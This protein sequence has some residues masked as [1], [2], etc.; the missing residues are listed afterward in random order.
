MDKIIHNTDTFTT[1]SFIMNHSAEKYEPFRNSQDLFLTQVNSE[2]LK[3]ELIKIIEGA[4]T[5]LKICSF[6]ITDKEIFEVLLNKAKNDNVAVFILTQLD[7]TKLSNNIFL[8]EEE[9][10]EQNE[11]IHL[12][13]IKT[14]YDN[15]AHVR[16]STSAHAKFVIAD[17]SKGFLMSANITTPS[18]TYN[19]ESGIYLLNQN[20]NQL[21]Q[22]FDVIFQKGTSYRQYLSSS[23]SNK[24]LV[25]QNET[26]IKE[27]WLPKSNDS[28]LK[29]TYENMEFSLLNE[30]IRI[31]Q[32]SNK[33]IYI[34][35]YS[36]VALQNL[37]N[38]VFEIK[39]AV[40][41]G[42]E[43]FVFS[44]GM[45][46]RNDH[47]KACNELSKIGCSIYGDV[48]NHSKAILNEN[49]GLIFTANIDGNHGLTNGFEVG[50]KLTKT[51]YSELLDFHKYLIRTSPFVFNP[52]PV[53]LELFKM[54]E[55][56]EKLKGISPPF[57]GDDL[58]IELKGNVNVK[59]EELEGQPI[60]YARSKESNSEQ[61]L[62]VSNSTFKINIVNNI[63][64]INES[65]KTIYNIDKFLLRYNNLKI[66]YNNES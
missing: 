28:D 33:F 55:Y 24:Q 51:Q 38:I 13:F 57:F 32:N 42:V 6:I 44:R 31:I 29:Y 46:Y 48:F 9:S 63:I 11:N 58:V 17:K 16:A 61:F 66:K 43:V 50:C 3:R 59:Q 47:L 12:T 65:S 53:R 14:L 18:L 7:P 30:I 8:T 26:T 35:T 25:V 27:E 52:S 64:Y 21:E 15:G 62:V 4:T 60:F 45:N 19:T 41:R 54:Y 5:V 23:K 37:E 40:E 1:G 49:E 10:K 22:L 56:L 39:S 2:S 34:S 36:I 20:V